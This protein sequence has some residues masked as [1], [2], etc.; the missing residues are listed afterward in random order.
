MKHLMFIIVLAFAFMTEVQAEPIELIEN[1]KIEPYFKLGTLRGNEDGHPEG[2][3]RKFFIGYGAEVTPKDLA[4]LINQAEESF[5]FEIWAMSEPTDEDRE[6]TSDGFVVFAQAK[7]EIKEGGPF[8]LFGKLDLTSWKRNTSLTT[9]EK[10]WG[11]LLFANATAGVGVEYES[12]YGRIGAILPFYTNVDSGERPDPRIG[13]TFNIGV[14]R[15][16][17][18]AEFFYDR[19]NFSDQNLKLCGARLGFPF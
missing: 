9:P 16:H 18:K 13:F 14:K 12:F 11:D 7:K 10:Y 2:S 6:L 4:W 8:Y 5:G 15:E 19:I 3:G 17:F 1:L